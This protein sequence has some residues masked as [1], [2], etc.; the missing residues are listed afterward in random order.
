MPL[1]FWD[2]AFLMVTHLINRTPTRVLDYD[3]PLHH[4]LG[5][6]PNYS[7][8]RVFGC[9]CWPKLRPYNAHKLQYRSTRCA[10]IGYSNLHK[11]YKCLGIPS[12]CVYISHDVI[13]DEA[14]FPF[15]ELSS[16]T[17]AHYTAEVLLLLH[18][19]G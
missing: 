6:T 3:T 5:V 15:V 2:Q 19:S 1:K 8:L 7:N 18:S 9:A 14:V 16:S 13:F 11:G 4:L 10:F 17:G 12:G